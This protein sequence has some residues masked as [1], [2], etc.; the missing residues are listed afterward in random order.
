LASEDVHNYPVKIRVKLTAL[1][2][3]VDSADTGPTPQSYQVFQM[4]DQQLTVQLAQWKELTQKDIPAF[5]KM[6]PS[7]GLSQPNPGKAA[8]GG[9][10]GAQ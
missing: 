9:A 3:A 5:E 4:L 10:G 1:Q 6:A 2:H 8:S 7:A